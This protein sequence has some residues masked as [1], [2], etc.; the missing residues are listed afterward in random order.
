MEMAGNLEKRVTG[1]RNAPG[2]LPPHAHAGKL[3]VQRKQNTAA[4]QQ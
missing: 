2:N 1:F 4:F 3:P